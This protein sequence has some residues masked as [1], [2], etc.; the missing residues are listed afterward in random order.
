MDGIPS[1][2]IK[3]GISSFIRGVGIECS[4]SDNNYKSKIGVLMLNIGFPGKVSKVGG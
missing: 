3:F 2:I 4:S 1:T